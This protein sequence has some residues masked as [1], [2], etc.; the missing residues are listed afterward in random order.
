MDILLLDEVLAVGDAAFQA[1]CLQRIRELKRAGTTIVFIS[2]DLSAV[3]GLCDRVLLVQRGQIIAEGCA[4]DVIAEYQSTA[5]AALPA[6]EDAPAASSSKKAAITSAAFY[7]LEGREVSAARNGGAVVARVNYIAR[8]RI[9]DAVFEFFFYTG[10]RELLCHLSTE[11]SE[12]RIDLEPGT[13]VAE[14]MIGEMSLSP[15]V[16]YT[17]ATI[18][19]RDAPDDIDW[20]RNCA[21][22][23]V[24]PGKLRRGQFYMPHEWRVKQRHSAASSLETQDENF[25]AFEEEQEEVLDVKPSRG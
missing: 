23:R 25:S 4:R 12:Q 6:E 5:H 15:D 14:F 20:Q 24:D 7:D 19:H 3:E 17:D 10:N 13:G 9:T 21:T 2:H 22:L 11:F 8:E 16:Y 18:K 1:K